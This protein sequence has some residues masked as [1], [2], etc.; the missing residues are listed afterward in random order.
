VGHIPSPL[1]HTRT[2]SGRPLVLLHGLGSSRSAW[3]PV[4]AGLAQ[5]FDVIAID[6]PGFGA[7]AP[8]P[9]TVEATPSALA[10]AVADFL[11][12]LGVEKPHVVGDSLGGW[13][14]T[15]LARTYPVASLTLLSPAGLWARHTPWYSRISLGATRWLARHATP[16]VRWLVGHPIGRVIVLGQTHGRP[17]RIP[18][19]AARAAVTAMATSPGFD[20][21]FRAT[22]HRRLD[23]RT[24][25]TAPTTVAFGSRDL[26][27]LPWQSR[28]IE[29]LPATAHRAALPG[30][31]HVPMA[32]DPAAV[33]QLV[34]ESV[35]RAVLVRG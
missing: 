17:T 9:A 23:A 11:A 18:A 20:A 21:A 14:A 35:A 3:N 4:L 12:E 5:Q 30:C 7:S 15:E 34:V 24:G 22:L 2:G 8:L 16:V 28:H 25:V 31:G 1:R 33:I 6:L 27:L 32:D 13:V 10:G 19:D 29:R 26:I